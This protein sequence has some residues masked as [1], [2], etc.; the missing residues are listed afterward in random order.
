MFR[1]IFFTTMLV[2]LGAVACG[3]EAPQG[4]QGGD[5]PKAEESS[6]AVTYACTGVCQQKYYS[7]L[8]A[9][10]G[11]ATCDCFAGNN[12]QRCVAVCTGHTPILRQC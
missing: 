4:G 3:A 7:Q 9:C 8:T 11:D 2:S 1:R 5:E 12:Y 6:S 10:D